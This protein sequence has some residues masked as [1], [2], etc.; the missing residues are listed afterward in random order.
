[1]HVCDIH[2]A[3]AIWIDIYL[4]H[5]W[6]TCG[7]YVLQIHTHISMHMCVVLVCAAL[8]YILAGSLMHW[9][10]AAPDDHRTVPV[11]CRARRAA[12]Q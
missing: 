1:M 11:S 12:N 4:V 10:A 6:C 7:A 9:A 3:Y 5:M 8:R 2:R